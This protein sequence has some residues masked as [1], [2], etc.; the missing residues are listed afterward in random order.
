VTLIWVMR[1]AYL[2]QSL[3]PKKIEVRPYKIKLLS[4]KIS[5]KRIGKHSTYR[6]EQ[7]FAKYI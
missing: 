4:F 2:I 7:R 3:I 5:A 6:M 1:F